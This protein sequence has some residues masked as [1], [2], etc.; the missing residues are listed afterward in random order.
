MGASCSSPDPG[1][2]QN[3]VASRLVPPGGSLVKVTPSLPKEEIIK[4]RKKKDQENKIRRT[5]DIIWSHFDR[6]GNNELDV[7]E[8]SALVAETLTCHGISKD[9]HFSVVEIEELMRLVDKDGNGSMSRNEF[10]EL[11]VGL[12]GLTEERRDEIAMLSIVMCKA[13][14]FVEALMKQT[15]PS[16][17]G[18]EGQKD[19]QDQQEVVQSSTDIEADDNSDVGKTKS[20]DSKKWQPEEE[21]PLPARRTS[22][23]KWELLPV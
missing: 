3:N 13:M 20:M 2:P 7:D 15:I 6:D 8:F 1:A 12:T 14:I 11:I 16:N 19:H 9:N 23:L 4:R 5:L 21:V 18:K 10:R 22:R 17:G